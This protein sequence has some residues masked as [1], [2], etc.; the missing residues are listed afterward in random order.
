MLNKNSN[1]WTRCK[2]NT[3]CNK[4]TEDPSAN[5][6]VTSFHQQHILKTFEN[7]WPILNSFNIREKVEDEKSTNIWRQKCHANVAKNPWK[8][9]QFLTS[10]VGCGLVRILKIQHSLFRNIKRELNTLVHCT[11]LYTVACKQSQHLLG[12][13]VFCMF[14]YI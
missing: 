1:S 2:N 4:D 10:H 11:V 6:L 9:K 3:C 5:E 13:I 14:K 7:L 8:Y 12:L